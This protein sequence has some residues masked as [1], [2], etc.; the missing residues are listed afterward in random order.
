MIAGAAGQFLASPTD[1]V[2]TRLQ[3][4]GKRILEGK[5]ARYDDIMLWTFP[6]TWEG[7]EGGGAQI[8]KQISQK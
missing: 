5:N 3:A 8:Y 4:D 1:L 6:E 7:G 2:K